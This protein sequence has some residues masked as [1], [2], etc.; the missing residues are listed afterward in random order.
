MGCLYLSLK[1]G[2]W[3]KKQSHGPYS[4]GSDKSHSLVLQ[5]TYKKDDHKDLYIFLTIFW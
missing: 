1:L 2:V 3:P 5:G 4:N